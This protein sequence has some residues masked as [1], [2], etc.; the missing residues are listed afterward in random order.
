[1]VL[2]SVVEPLDD[3]EGPRPPKIFEK[4]N[5]F[6]ENILNNLKIFK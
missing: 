3:H 2:L 5:F 1:M 4:N 6:F